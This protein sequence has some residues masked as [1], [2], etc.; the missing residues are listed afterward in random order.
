MC[1]DLNEM[2][3]EMMPVIILSPKTNGSFMDYFF[4][5]P[6]L[7]AGSMLHSAVIK[8]RQFFFF[9]ES[10][11]RRAGKVK[12]SVSCCLIRHNFMFFF[13]QIYLMQWEKRCRCNISELSLRLER[14]RWSD[15]AILFGLGGGGRGSKTVC[16]FGVFS[17][18]FTPFE[19]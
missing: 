8:F 10:V 19:S 3:V 5:A 17:P 1:A 7:R 15:A 16:V 6:F 14:W 11:F 9:T 4:S 13:V 12:H 2:E 18:A